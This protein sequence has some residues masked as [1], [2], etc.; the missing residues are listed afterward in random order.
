M[1]TITRLLVV[2]SLMTVGCKKKT[3]VVTDDPGEFTAPPPDPAVE[4]QVVSANP[5]TYEPQQIIDVTLFGGGFEAGAQ[6]RV[7]PNPWLAALVEDPNTMSVQAPGLPEGTYDITVRQGTSEIALRSGI[8]VKGKAVATSRC[9]ALVMYFDLDGA[10]LSAPARKALDS[11]LPCL[12]LKSRIRLEGHADER[13]TTNYNVSLGERRALA[14]KRYLATAG[15]RSSVI[16][17]TSFGEERP[18]KTGSNE[19]AW[20]ANR[21]VDILTQ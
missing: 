5:S 8:R 7:G 15:V 20:A 17:V 2:V 10:G 11:A 19:A 1:S 3:P 21:R 9:D 18:A 14:V 4:L 13:G 16:A 6:V 12:K